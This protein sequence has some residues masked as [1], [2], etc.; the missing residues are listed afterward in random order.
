MKRRLFIWIFTCG[1]LCAEAAQAQPGAFSF[2]VIAHAFK[3]A[4]EETALSDAIAE[5]DA[6]NL[7]FVVANGIKASDEP[8]SDA[9][10]NHRK[11]LLNQAKNGLILSLTAS[12][13]TGCKRS[14]GRSAAM[15]R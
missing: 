14:N 9:V 4:P 15:D 13:W 8:C 7:A 2:G 5:T 6:D 11:A 3:A 10:Y 1:M 12:D